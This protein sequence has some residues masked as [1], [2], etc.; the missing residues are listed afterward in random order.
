VTALAGQGTLAGSVLY[1]EF[2]SA[3]AGPPP[4]GPGAAAGSIL[5]VQ[6]YADVFTDTFLD[7]FGVAGAPQQMPRAASGSPT[8]PPG[9]KAEGGQLR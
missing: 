6:F 7:T 4:A 8:A 1:V 5:A 2:G 3:Q 9:P